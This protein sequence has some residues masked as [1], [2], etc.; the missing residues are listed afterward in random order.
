[1]EE[2]PRID[3]QRYRSPKMK[4]KYAFKFGLYV[5]VFLLLWLW[6]K[7]QQND[8]LEREK[9]NETRLKNQK[10]IQINDTQIEP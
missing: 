10:E 6:Y 4:R 1:M 7:K 2:K 3:L 8:Q 9:I 5:L